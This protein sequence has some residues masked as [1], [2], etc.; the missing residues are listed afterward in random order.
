[1][2]HR[3]CYIFFDN[4]WIG[5]EGKTYDQPA[6]ELYAVITSILSCCNKKETFQCVKSV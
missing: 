2:S 1:M 4:E 3:T 5:R 6:T